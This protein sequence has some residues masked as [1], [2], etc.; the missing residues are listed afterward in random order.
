MIFCGII[1][2]TQRFLCVP[3]YSF[4]VWCLPT[5]TVGDLMNAIQQQTRYRPAQQI[6][7][8]GYVDLRREQTLD[9]VLNAGDAAQ[10]SL[11]VSQRKDSARLSSLPD[12][13]VCFCF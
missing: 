5:E 6:L 12:T 7:L 1:K 9:V 11:A 3:T 2:F 13:Q 10:L 8:F 4:D